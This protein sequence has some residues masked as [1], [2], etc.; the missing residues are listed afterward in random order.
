[1]TI[2][3]MVIEPLSLEAFLRTNP[4]FANVDCYT[5]SMGLVV[6]TPPSKGRTYLRRTEDA[7]FLIRD[8]RAYRLRGIDL[9]NKTP[10]AVSR[11]LRRFAREARE[12]GENFQPLKKGPK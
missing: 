10:R 6:V 11:L 1:M 7:A 5:T 9:G 12:G 4:V 2:H 8:G 3:I